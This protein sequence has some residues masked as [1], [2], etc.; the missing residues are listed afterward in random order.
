MI[1]V[2]LTVGSRYPVNRKKIRKFVEDFL[3]SQ[4]VFHAVIS[5]SIV[6]DRKMKALNE[7]MLGHDGVTDVLSFPQYDKGAATD[8]ESTLEPV[9]Q[10]NEHGAFVL[11]PIE[12]INLGDIVICFPEIVRQSMKRGKMVDDHICYYIEHSLNHLL[13]NHHE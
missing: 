11:P 6:G 8:Y 7:K 3:H 4:K 1:D 9:P 12:T 5:I 10:M 13:G 2:L